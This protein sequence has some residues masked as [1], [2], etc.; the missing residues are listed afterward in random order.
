MSAFT[1]EGVITAIV[2]PF[3]NGE[4]DW[5][6]LRKLV[7]QQ[8]DGGMEGFV[9]SGS[10]GEAATLRREE[11]EELLKFVKSEVSGQ[12]PVIFGSGTNNT[13]ESC[14]LARMGESAG[15]DALL[16]V[17]PYYNKPPQRGLE[18]HFTKIAESTELP[19]ILY[20]IPGRSVAKIEPTTLA[21]LAKIQ[22]IVGLK[23]ST[24]TVQALDEMFAV[25][26][27]NFLITCGDD[28][29]LLESLDRGARGI[30]S[31][32]SHLVPAS[33][34][35]TSDLGRRGEHEKAKIEFQKFKKLCTD[36]FLETNPMP[37]KMGLYKMG[38]LA[39]PECRLP[40]V[41]LDERFIDPL[42]NS[43]R[44]AGIAV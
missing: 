8:L 41:T 42:L 10:T 17:T 7:R 14:E 13:V 38:I 44:A 9:V 5:K 1:F 15:A 2:T 34:R 36:I 29:I 22:N 30:I 28:P 6:S 16:V 12:V 23:E 19:V 4:I 43:M 18:A 26:P 20:N 33:V 35:Q 25:V 11:K 40:L 39:S 21:R 24:G 32:A 3:K 37:V 31:V 27:E